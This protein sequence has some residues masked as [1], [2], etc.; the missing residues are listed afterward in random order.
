MIIMSHFS[1]S[2]DD[3]LMEGYSPLVVHNFD[4]PHQ[5]AVVAGVGGAP[6]TTTVTSGGAVN[7]THTV[8][9]SQV[10]SGQPGTHNPQSQTS[11][12]CT[13]GNVRMTEIVPTFDGTTDVNQ[14]IEK[15]EQAAL[16]LPGVDLAQWAV[17]LA[18]GGAQSVLRNLHQ[19]NASTWVGVRQALQQAYGVR[20][21]ESIRRM[22]RRIGERETVYEYASNLRSLYS[23][24][25]GNP[26]E[27][28]VRGSLILGLP[29]D[30]SASLLAQGRWVDTCP[31]D[32]L[33]ER[34]NVLLQSR[35][36]R[37]LIS[38]SSS[39]T[40][41]GS[42]PTGGQQGH[43][44]SISRDTSS[45]LALVPHKQNER[46]ETQRGDN[47]NP[48]NACF[49]CG[50]MTHWAKQCKARPPPRKCG[51]CRGSH[52]TKMCPK[53]RNKRVSPPSD[54]PKKGGSGGHD[55]DDPPA[56]QGSGASGGIA[57]A[58]VTYWKFEGT[59]FQSGG[60]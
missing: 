43:G 56:V 29:D 16:I 55:D 28:V 19:N 49:R 8:S 60:V 48:A 33:V 13:G 2:D 22:R 26:D 15:M 46:S 50:S 20:P 40:Q 45:A 34:A 4:M 21:H 53:K 11:A 47:N 42:G 41:G 7:T 18:R 5:D 37:R 32:E 1:W 52:K 14:W 12:P 25:G 59:P 17:V 6:P 31:F 51:W 30:I 10:G 35:E 23:A 44:S 27:V 57:G 54:P 9:G 3:D 38:K 39:T 36:S 58:Q 24:A